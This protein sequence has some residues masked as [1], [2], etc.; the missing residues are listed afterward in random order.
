M[1]FLVRHQHRSKPQRGLPQGAIDA[2][3]EHLQVHNMTT[4]LPAMTTTQVEFE[5]DLVQCYALVPT[6]GVDS[7]PFYAMKVSSISSYL[8][9]SRELAK[10]RVH[11]P[12]PLWTA[13]H[14][15]ECPHRHERKKFDMESLVGESS[16][17]GEKTTVKKS[18]VGKHCEV[19][20]NVKLAS[21]VLM[22]NIKIGDGV[23]LE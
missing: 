15:F 11:S 14:D 5:D 19:G 10:R 23:K 16:T 18:V 3:R 7:T 4:T 20:N 2:R 22:D 17:F 13:P 8:E 9:I 1:P 12:G 6:E 21:S